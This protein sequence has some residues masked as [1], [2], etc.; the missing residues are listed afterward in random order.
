MKVEHWRSQANYPAEQLDY[1]NLLAACP[2]GAGERRDARHCDTRKGEREL[3]RNPAKGDGRIASKDPAFE[4]ELNEVL[5]LNTPFLI[6]NRRAV[7][8]GFLIGLGK[9]P[10]MRT[11]RE[12]KKYLRQWNG[13]LDDGDL[14]P[15]CQGVVYYLRK[16]LARLQAQ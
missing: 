8:D 2:G 3:S 10:G 5:N 6:R 14:R 7:I 4:I 11:P 12:L 15:F 13:E 16:R 1:S 9:D